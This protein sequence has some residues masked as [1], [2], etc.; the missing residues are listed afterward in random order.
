MTEHNVRLTSGEIA[1][2]W[3]MYMNDSLSKCV[4][5]HFLHTVEDRDI[6]DVI[7]YARSLSLKH[8][9]TIVTIMNG[10]RH[11]IPRGFTDEDVNPAAPRLYSDVF[12]MN[13]LKLFARLGLGFYG[14]HLHLCARSDLRDLIEECLA[15]STRLSKMADDVM[16]KK[17]I[18]TRPPAIP[19]PETV[20]FVQKAGFLNG[21][22]GDRRSLNAVEIANLFANIRMNAMGKAALMGFSQVAESEE[23][24]KYLLRGVAIADKHIEVLSS[25]LRAD[26]IP[27]PATFEAEVTASATSPF[28]DKLLM[29]HTAA[30]SQASQMSYGLAM[31]TCLR[32]DIGIDIARLASE[33]VKFAEDGAELMIDRQWLEKAP[34]AVERRAIAAT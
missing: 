33:I 17:G 7:E 16:L 1:T 2:L 4:L 6:R 26:D 25:K 27:A 3:T 8:L 9:D 34:G 29:Y 31:G 13:Y 20:E 21:Y 11:P 5:S 24:R 19:I 14:F 23:V 28:S 10:E 15:S 30:L 22:F 32:R 12:Y 18:Y